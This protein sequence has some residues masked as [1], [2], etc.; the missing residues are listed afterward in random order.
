MIQIIEPVKN[1]QCFSQGLAATFSEKDM[2]KHILMAYSPSSC[3][4]ELKKNLVID[5]RPG[6]RI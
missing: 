5:G 3:L 2:R 1:L 6:F 4:M